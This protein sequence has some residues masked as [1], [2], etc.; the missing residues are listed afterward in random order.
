M[1]KNNLSHSYSTRI[2]LYSA[3]HRI[4]SVPSSL[5]AVSHCHLKGSR[6]VPLISARLAIRVIDILIAVAIGET[7][8]AAGVWAACAPCGMKVGVGGVEH[9]TDLLGVG[10]GERDWGRRLI[11]EGMS[12]VLS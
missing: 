1:C 8:A 12:R 2:N 9:D 11:D 6:E 4:S 3:S 10:I 5:P 7:F